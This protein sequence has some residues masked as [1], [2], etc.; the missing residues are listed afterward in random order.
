M[1]VIDTLIEYLKTQENEYETSTLELL[2]ACNIKY[3]GNLM[4]L[5]YDLVAKVREHGML[6]DGLDHM[7]SLEGTNYSI[8]YIVRKRLGSMDDET[9]KNACESMDYIIRESLMYLNNQD[10]FFEKFVDEYRKQYKEFE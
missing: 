6:F 9:W 3:E 5:H 2:E 1:E 7:F 10:E 4:D 8:P